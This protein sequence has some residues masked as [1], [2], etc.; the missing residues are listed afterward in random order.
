MQYQ[1]QQSHKS[2]NVKD[3]A[4]R[5]RIDRGCNNVKWRTLTKSLVK[6]IHEN[7]IH[8]ELKWCKQLA[9]Y[10]YVTFIGEDELFIYLFFY[11]EFLKPSATNC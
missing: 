8:C 10:K 9:K 7:F 6:K 3:R 4:V 1:N 5:R 2:D 11:Y